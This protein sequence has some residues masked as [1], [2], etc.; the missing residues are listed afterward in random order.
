MFVAGLDSQ[1]FFGIKDKMHMGI[2]KNQWCILSD[3]NECVLARGSLTG[4]FNVVVGSRRPVA[5]CSVQV[6]LI[7]CL[8]LR[9]VERHQ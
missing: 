3:M 7:A 4:L 6:C 9:N 1:P 5:R 2:L 8:M